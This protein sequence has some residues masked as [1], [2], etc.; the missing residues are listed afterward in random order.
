MVMHG[1][2]AQLSSLEIAS[3]LTTTNPDA[4]VVLDRLLRILA[5]FTIVTFSNRVGPNGQ[6]E[7][8]YGLGPV[9]QF[10]VKNGGGG[11]YSAFAT[12]MYDKVVMNSWKHLKDAVL[13]GGVPFN[14]AHGMGVFDYLGTNSR[15]YNVFYDGMDHHSIMVSKKIL[16]NYKGFEGISSLVDVGGATG[17]T[18]NMIIPK[19]PSIKGIN[20]DLPHI[21]KDAPSFPGIEHVGGDMY[22]NVPKGDAIFMKWTFHTAGNNEQ[23]IK[24]LKNC[25][26]ALPEDG[27]VIICEHVV[28]DEPGETSYQAHTSFIFDAMLL[29]I[30]GGRAR[31]KHESHPN[32][33]LLALI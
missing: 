22:I 10:L 31:T 16:D 23:C 5:N 9:C 17:V 29:T 25:H 27:K 21:I 32:I 2:D 18:L 26:E 14:L 30:P 3:Q 15:F 28:S 19:Y 8:V 20:F 6:V 1:P 12:L 33:E 13:D 24:L 4:A 11:S 7:R